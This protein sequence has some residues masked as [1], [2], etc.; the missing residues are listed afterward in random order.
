MKQA[1]IFCVVIAV[2]GG[3]CNTAQSD[4]QKQSDLIE[5]TM[6]ENSPGAVATSE[7]GSYLN[8]KVDGTEW[9][10]ASMV[11]NN[12]ASSNTML[13]RGEKG[14]DMIQFQL[15]K[16]S[17]VVDKKKSFTNES[18]A[19]IYME[20]NNG[21]LSGNTGEIEI[22]KMDAE[23]VEGVFHFS[24]TGVVYDAAG[25]TTPKTVEVTDGRFRIPNR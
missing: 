13:V 16:P 8:A 24:A 19:G 14:E 2:M 12:D 3:S 20:S 4:A 22:T 10:A 1:L 6:K 18:P 7:S 21:L 5:K 23:W 9:A 11:P 25:N 17:L 15:W